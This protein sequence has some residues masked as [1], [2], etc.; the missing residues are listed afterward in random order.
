M[1]MKP[2]RRSSHRAASLLASCNLPPHEQQ[3]TAGKNKGGYEASRS[4]RL[5]GSLLDRFKSTIAEA[6][7][8]G[9]VKQAKVKDGNADW[10]V[11]ARLVST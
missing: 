11:R 4:L 5:S 8:A 9:V 2:V 7:I 6:A 3:A 1:G 10:E